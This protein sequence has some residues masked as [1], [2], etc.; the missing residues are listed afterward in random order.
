MRLTFFYLTLLTIAACGPGTGNS[1]TST[2][3]SGPGPDTST[4]EPTTG[5]SA[6]TSSGT[7]RGTSSGTS[8]TGEPGVT[9]TTGEPGVT[10]TTGEPGTTTGEPG[11]TASE[12]GTTT[13]LVPGEAECSEDADC[14]LNNDCCTCEGLPLDTDPS[15]CQNDCRQPVCAALGI[16]AAV[17]NLGVCE[18]ARLSC[19]ATKIACDEEAPKCPPGTVPE[20]TPLC[21]TNRCVPAAL[22]DVVPDCALC[23][24]DMM[25]VQKVA[26]T[27]ESS[28]QPIPP[29]CGG[30]IACECVGDLVCTGNFG[31]CSVAGPVVQCECPNC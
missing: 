3:S 10:T 20:T 4:G 30:K 14:K 18:P 28:C 23:P 26:F 15:D 17:C 16:E 31:L 6:G 7:S 25:C 1:D 29:D 22:C 24:A 21:W 11:T 27:V 13:G 5:T 2:S 19:D 9:T 12:P 8:T